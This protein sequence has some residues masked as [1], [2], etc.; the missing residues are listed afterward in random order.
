MKLDCPNCQETIE[1]AEKRPAFCSH[2]GQALTQPDI[3]LA[4]TLASPP[5]PST[6]PSGEF[7]ANRDAPETVGQYRV[8]REL[9]RGGMGVVYEAEHE[10]SGR[11]VALK[12]LTPGMA[13]SKD[14]MERFLRE[15]R[16]AAALSHPRSTFVYEAGEFSGQPYI[17]MERMPGRTL[18][19][20]CAERGPLPINEAVDYALDIIDGLEAAHAVG[21]IHRDVKPSNCFLDEN[22]RVK[23]GDFGLSKSLVSDAGLTRT[24]AFMG[25]PLFAAP[26]QV[27]AGKIDERT[28]I[29]AVGATL[30]YLITQRG[31][32][33]GDPA[34]VIAQ[35][36]SDRAP[37]LSSVAPKIPRD[38]DRIVAQTLEKDSQRRFQKLD[39]LRQALL[40]F[41]TQGTAAAQVGRRVGAYFVDL[42]CGQLSSTALT[43]IAVIAIEAAQVPSSIF[44]L[45]YL[46][47]LHQAMTV[48]TLVI[49]FARAESYWG[50]SLGKALLGL[51]VIR[52]DG[53]RPRFA[54]A[55]LRS[56]IV[57]GSMWLS[58]AIVAAFVDFGSG[59][60]L[61]I[62]A[63][64]VSS[65]SMLRSQLLVPLAVV[66][67]LICFTSMRAQ[68]GYRGW[69]ELASGTRVVRL[70]AARA[71]GR[72][73][74]V[75]VM[76]ATAQNQG[77]ESFGPFRVIGLLGRTSDGDV[78]L[79]RDHTLGRRVWIYVRASE[80]GPTNPK[81]LELSRPA[82]PRWLQ[83]G[84]FDGRR[85]DAYEAVT[86]S[87]VT[88]A[89]ARPEGVDWSANRR[90]LLELV[91]EL[92]FS[93]RDG[94]LPPTIGLDQVWVDQ[95]G[96]AKLIE[97]RLLP[98]ASSRPTTATNATN[99]ETVSQLARQ[100]S[101]L[102]TRGI[103][104]PG[105]ARAFLGE[106]A[107]RPPNSE[108][109]EWAAHAL[110]DI[111]DRPASITWSDRLVS[112]ACCLG[113]EYQI[114]QIL[115]TLVT[116]ALCFNPAVSRNVGLA[117]GLAISLALPVVTGLWLRGGP[118]FRL[119]GIEVWR[120]DGAVAGRVRCGIRSFIAW[121]IPMAQQGT[122]TSLLAFS[123]RE[124]K[125]LGVLSDPVL[126]WTLNG[127]SCLMFFWLAG[128]IY[129]VARPARGIQDVIA[130]TCLV[131]E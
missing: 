66:P 88:L 67:V 74:S 90:V 45:K 121:M 16:L 38:L 17:A 65:T 117:V 129:A 43:G 7:T 131:P 47:F 40:P 23:V 34:A 60:G 30:F 52:M 125:P 86:G 49:Y 103:S 71:V 22:G 75:P 58:L 96:R 57:P 84:L 126:T 63:T 54:Q 9:G 36:S 51:R 25:T 106:L 53:A 37:L 77:V 14:S 118:I 72:T 35:I 93:M 112:L 105:H 124:G 24:G 98:T 20:V 10:D 109:I 31:P 92:E 27:R 113:T 94:T 102:C 89:L 83:G 79:A 97:E 4:A 100:A 78:W 55:L 56:L 104:L 80:A 69:H 95:D 115:I 59:A 116:I 6:A 39:E 127:V 1:Y 50:R 81:R 87:P 111:A 2:C 12:V 82:R 110:R 26:E 41:A 46:V 119:M 33:V 28:D 70:R 76:A 48:L 19:H 61:A 15:G 29:Y 32:F 11:R 73:S 13:Q 99:A 130:G 123:A 21:V 64:S 3:H 107:T 122:V 42:I 44:S 91:E 68:N 120:T 5:A 108:S 85:W 18:H 128:V 114:Y 8:L 62:A 101:E